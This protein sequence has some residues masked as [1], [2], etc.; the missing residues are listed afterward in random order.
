L[1]Y[2]R[3]FKKDDKPPSVTKFTFQGYADPPPP[4]SP[5]ATEQIWNTW[6]YLHH[7][8][9]Y[10]KPK[11]LH[12]LA[13]YSAAAA[14][15]PACRALQLKRYLIEI[16][17]LNVE[18]DFNKLNR[19]LYND[20][21]IQ[22]TNSILCA[23]ERTRLLALSRHVS[24]YLRQRSRG[25][26]LCEWD[27]RQVLEHVIEPGKESLRISSQLLLNTLFG[28]YSRP[29]SCPVR[30]GETLLAQVENPVRCKRNWESLI[31]DV[32]PNDRVATVLQKALDR[33]M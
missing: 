31:R 25:E 11:T 32:S 19:A 6:T 15:S 8:Q 33:C 26:G 16:I 30:W 22:A 2:L 12:E 29:L 7:P 9:L 17:A 21:T 20:E 10:F 14:R 18:A 3:F 5:T 27:W 1:I 4:Y 23:A 28:W 24:E 13:W